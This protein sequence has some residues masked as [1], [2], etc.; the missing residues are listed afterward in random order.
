MSLLSTFYKQCSITP[1]NI[2]VVEGDRQ[3]S[4]RQLQQSL[5]HITASIQSRPL[6][7]ERIAIAVERGI[8]A[9][10]AILSVLKLNACYIPLDLKNPGNR[11]SYIVND[12]DVQCVIGR[13]ICPEWLDKPELWL[14]ID[15]LSVS[16][17]EC[18]VSMPIKQQ[19]L[20]A[21]LYTSGSTGNPKGVALSHHAMCNFADW[22]IET[23]NITSTDRIAS[24][25]PFHFDLSVFDLFSSLRCGASIH[26]VPAML[27]MAPSRLTTWLS[28]NKI[29]TWYTVP[30]LLSFLSLKGSLNTI[31][32]PHL[33]TLLFAGEVFPTPQLIKFCELLAHV[34]FYN[35]Y[36]PTETNVCCYWPVERNQLIPDQPIPI[37][38]PA[39]NSV[40]TISPDNNELL[41]QS[42]NNLAGYWQ[43]GKL[44]P[45]LS[46]D[47]TFHTGDKVSLNEKNEYCYHGRLDRMLKYSGYRVEPA[48]IEQAILQN[49]EVES[50]AVFGIKD[51]TSGHRPVAVIVL[52]RNSNLSDLIK[53]VKQKLPA[54]MHPC[55]FITLNSLPYLSN[56]KTDYKTLQMQMENT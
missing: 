40:L 50:C 44:I 28:E 52:K 41:V 15:Q 6:C 8:D 2:A 34:N 54:Y 23:F 38:L 51:S 46:A 29:T 16:S 39:C 22:A 30:S 11:L 12:A 42:D 48:E 5:K 13:G 31:P 14:D 25:A 45:A 21:I 19:S 3:L 32:L 4:Y 18:P 36:G 33:K 17:K 26:F 9:T 37:G 10:Q 35:L 49:D 27:T 1:N 56:G 53:Q 24:L 55:K 47:N 43:Q 7:C 20:A